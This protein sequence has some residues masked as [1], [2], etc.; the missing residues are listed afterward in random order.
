MP[1]GGR[2]EGAGRKPGSK[3]KTARDTVSVHV[4]MPAEIVEKLETLADKRQTTKSR[5]ILEACEKHI[6]Q[7]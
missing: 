5:L 6:S 2:R 3:N 7:L 1:S 4:R